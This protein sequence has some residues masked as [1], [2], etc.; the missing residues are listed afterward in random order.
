MRDTIIN[1]LKDY[2]EGKTTLLSQEIADL[3]IKEFKKDN[4][5][6]IPLT[7]EILR[8]LGFEYNVVKDWM[9]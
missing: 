6:G 9:K 2:R 3:I 5:I 4:S 7:R 8:E 1:Y